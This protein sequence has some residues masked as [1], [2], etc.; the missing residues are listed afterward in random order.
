MNYVD[1]C[2]ILNENPRQ[3][4]TSS[5]TFNYCAEVTLPP[6]G[7]K[8]P[9]VLVLNV[10]GKTGDAFRSL[11]KADRV[12]IHGSKLR[13]DLESKTYSL[14]GGVVAQVTEAFPVF[15][16]VILTGRCI[17]DIDQ[18]DARAF[19]TTADGLMIANQTLSVNTGRNQADLFNFYAINTAQDKF[20]QA[21]LLVNMTRKG[22]GLTIRARIVTDAW[23]DKE[24]NQRRSV[25]KLQLVQMTL[26]PKTSESQTKQVTSQTTVA[27]T[28]NVASLWGGKTVEESSDPWN[29]GPNTGL[30]DL[31]GQYGNAPEF[32]DEPPF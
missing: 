17:K 32:N 29:A 30:P 22:T 24:T 19:K 16:D 15:N 13:F 7:N 28:E 10:Y 8:A 25:T 1:V 20:N 11:N 3:V 21:E 2:A 27:S 5:T 9:T 6:V 18:T 23:T 31:P 12:Y 14:N 26:A 4:Y